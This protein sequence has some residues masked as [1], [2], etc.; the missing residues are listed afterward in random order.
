M[1]PEQALRSIKRIYTKLVDLQTPG[2]YY[3][4]ELSRVGGYTRYLEE[5]MTGLGQA[6]AALEEHIAFRLL[7][8]PSGNIRPMQRCDTCEVEKPATG[9]Y[10]FRFDPSKP[11]STTC[12]RCERR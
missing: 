10:F 8:E 2:Y 11:L 3:H 5:A 7:D 9:H 12:K 1:T 6:M 4:E